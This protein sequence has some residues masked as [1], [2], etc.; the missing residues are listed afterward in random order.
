MI[1]MRTPCG[2]AMEGQGKKWKGRARELNGETAS[3]HAEEKPDER[4]GDWMVCDENMGNSS[5][6]M[7]YCQDTVL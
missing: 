7:D 5:T 4:R 2:R 1:L 3:A 6:E